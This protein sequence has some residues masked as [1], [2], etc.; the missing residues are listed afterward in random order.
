MPRLPAFLECL[1]LFVGGACLLSALLFVY[2][3]LGMLGIIWTPCTC[4]T[5]M[6]LQRSTPQGYYFEASQTSCSGV[7][8]GP[9]G[10]SVFASKAKGGKKAL[11]FEY[12]RMNDDSRDAEP[13][14]T[15]VDDRTVRIAVKYVAEII[16]KSRNWDALAVKY[17][18]GCVVDT[19]G[20]PPAA[21]VRD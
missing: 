10:I 17:D 13:A 1:A 11:I 15:L 6:L 9:A 20:N 3:I 12:E 16:C 2:M 8:K 18:I 4:L 14:V 7:G 5:D 21:C 19:D